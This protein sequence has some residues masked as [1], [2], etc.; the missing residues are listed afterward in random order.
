MIQFGSL[1]QNGIQQIAKG[2]YIS[3]CKS[4]HNKIT[5]RKALNMAIDE[6]MER[7]SKVFLMGEEVAFSGGTYGVSKGLLEKYGDKRVIDTPISEIGYTGIGSGAAFYGLRPIIEFMTMNFALQAIDHIVNSSGKTFYMS[8]GKIANPIVFR[9]PN[10]AAAG[11]GAQ[12]S[13]CFAAWYSHVPCLKV[14]VP[15]SA[16]DAKGLLKAAIRDPDPVIVLEDEILYGESF[17]MSAHALANDFVI[18]I[19]QA[20]V[21]R[22]GD[23]V[24]IATYG[25]AVGT[26]LK[27]AEELALSSG[28]SAEV[29]NLRTIRPLDFETVAE[30]VAKTNRLVTVEQGWPQSGVGSEIC[31]RIVESPLFDYL[32]SPVIRVTGADVPMPYTKELEK[33]AIPQPEDVFLA[34]K[35][36]FEH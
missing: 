15:W 34:V 28:I 12:H 21:E 20:K 2:R 4:L 13:Q 6:E 31:A 11:V 1:F 3:V 25:K 19:G 30:S 14:V 36:L 26:A 35:K 8:G 5:V 24:T 9:G 22:T 23:H 17:P 10:G 27:A 33:H 16:E 32:D 7:D 29:I 18:P